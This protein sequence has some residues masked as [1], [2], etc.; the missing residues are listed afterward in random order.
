MNKYLFFL[1]FCMFIISKSVFADIYIYV[2]ENGVL[3]F[4]NVPT[5]AN[6][7]FYMKEFGG[8]SGG[9]FI[10][11]SPLESILKYTSAI[12]SIEPDLIKAVIKAESSF[13]KNAVSRKGAKGLMQLMPSIIK[14]YNV[15]DP[16]DPSQNI[17]A[18]ARYLKK[19]M[20]MYKG[21]IDLTLAAYNAGPG[22]VARYGGIPPFPETK[23]YVKKVKKYYMEYK[24]KD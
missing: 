11:E 18:G 14:K 20:S 9:M 13:I 22:A 17:M 23:K 1:F 24:N 19:L 2:D 21:N 16:F 5:S 7:K 12:T 15:K 6:Y 8:S 4:S 3:S 10:N